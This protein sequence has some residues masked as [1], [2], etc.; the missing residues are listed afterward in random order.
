MGTSI[1]IDLGTTNSCMAVVEGGKAKVIENAE[2]ERTTPSVVAFG[3]KGEHLVGQAARRQQA[4]NPGRTITSIK[5][6]MGSKKRIKIDGRKYS[7]Q[8]I[9]AMI[10]A[11]LKK[12]AEAYLGCDVTNAVI[13][14]PAY[15][16][17]AQRQ[18]TKDAGAIAGLQVDRIIN[19]P[20]AA[21]LSY[22]VDKEEDKAVMVFDL[23]GGTFDVSILSIKDGVV[24]V[25]AT[26]GDNHL[27]G[28]DFD[29]ML[30]NSLYERFKAD[31][32]IDIASDKQA[33]SRVREAAETAKKE[34]S[35]VE[36]AQVNLPFLATGA[37]GNPLHFETVVTRADFDKLTAPLVERTVGPVKQAMADAR[38]SA[39]DLGRVLMVGGS[40]RIPAVRAAVRKLTDIEP[41]HNINPDESVALGAAEQGG[42]LAGAPGRAGEL[43]LLDVTPH[44]LGIEIIGDATSVLIPRNSTLPAM[45]SEVYTT[46]AAFQT[47]V[48]I[49][50]LQ[51]ES[52]RASENV[53]MGRFRLGGL[54]RSAAKPQIEV[55]FQI[56]TDG[57]VHVTAKELGTGQDASIR[58]EGS[59]NLSSHEIET[60][61]RRLLGSGK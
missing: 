20:T 54:K 40:S 10:L 16:T 12:D 6:L 28:D 14:V 37:D 21:A 26:A 3:K 9:S 43:L 36:Q 13:T 30:A 42:V 4:M 33:L 25:I 38:M 55:T 8:E 24:E 60:A 48:D 35:E 29:A 22:G 23:G 34:L 56:D 27:G 15:F 52:E 61:K 19:E 31:T 47:E 46:A 7:P 59:S 17:D 53:S 49:H 39:R 58:I 18:A 11:K 2:G 51:G 5:R 41:S 57:I 32:G 44:S 45:H 50:V 1:G